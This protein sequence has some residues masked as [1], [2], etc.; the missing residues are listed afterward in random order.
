MLMTEKL[1]REFLDAINQR[2]VAEVELN[3]NTRL[4]IVKIVEDELRNYISI[5]TLPP[6]NFP[7]GLI[8]EDDGGYGELSNEELAKAVAKD[9]TFGWD[10]LRQEK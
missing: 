9:E 10:V 4:H 3:R 8:H 5:D 7:A 1:L 2:V 6:A